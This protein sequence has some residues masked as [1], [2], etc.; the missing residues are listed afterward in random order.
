VT[1]IR[2]SKGYVYVLILIAHPQTDRTQQSG[3]H[4]WW[5]TSPRGGAIRHLTG[6][7]CSSRYGAPIT[8]RLGSAGLQEHGDSV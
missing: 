3:R 4:K 2:R 8:T 5:R 1:K 7:Q 6:A